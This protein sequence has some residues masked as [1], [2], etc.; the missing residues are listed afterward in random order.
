MYQANPIGIDCE[1]PE[2]LEIV[3]LS[4]ER[5]DVL[6]VNGDLVHK[7]EKNIHPTKWRR[8]IYSVYIKENEPFWPGWTAKRQLLE[9]YD[10][11]S[12]P[13]END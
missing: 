12:C 2:G 13:N 11:P 5:G 3:H 1:I 9:R 4:Y 7:A 10:S 8:T 6:A